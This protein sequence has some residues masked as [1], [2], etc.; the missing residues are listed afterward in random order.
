MATLSTFTV[1]GRILAKSLAELASALG[2]QPQPAWAWIE[3]GGIC[4][5]TRRL[6]PGDLFVAIP[7]YD[8][9][10][11]DFMA[12]AIERGAVAVL[13]EQSVELAVPVLKAKCARTALAQ[14]SAVFYDHPTRE[15][16]TV[17]VT[18]TNGKTTTCHWSAE[19]LGRSQTLLLSTVRNPALGISG[20]TTPPSSIIQHLARGAVEDGTHNMILE[21]SSA[22][23]AQDRVS[24][25]DFDACVFTNFSPE[26]LSHHNGLAAYR[27]AKLKLFEGLKPEAWAILNADDALHAAIAK[28]TSARV[29]T[30]GL[31]A[32]ADVR[33]DDI[34]F[35]AQGSR[36]TVV[37]H[38]QEP[39]AISLPLPGKHHISNALAAISVG[40][41][42]GITV[43]LIA[44]RLAQVEP[45]PGRDEVF[46]RADGLVAVI[47]FAHNPSSL[48]AVL[49]SLR[50]GY[51]RIIALFGCPG[52]GE[53]EKRVAMGEVG[54]RWADA[55]VLTS[56]NPKNED[57]LAIAR[58]I[59]IGIGDS[60]VPVTISLDRKQA[61]QL[62][63]SLAKAGDV[64]LLAG[65]GHETEQLI[66]DKRVP[67]SDAEALRELGFTESD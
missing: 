34:H 30:Y 54:G 25:I 56:D 52:D 17:G 36:F 50:S 47:D 51:S 7:G 37:V 10:G 64:V 1:W 19:L 66:E 23:I 16:F 35:G 13:S 61:I 33:A 38:G 55:I 21:A 22:G 62:A 44:K 31:D 2:S 15:L 24:A 41:V 57:P 65:K 60:L 46:R 49:K 67:F 27:N 18:G 4:E 3:I 39:E 26:H 42:K 11:S 40:V 9:D 29:L 12:R 43:P 53:H 59:Q 45:I 20:L 6:R 32:E 48:E 63:L 14:L 28:A 58:E 5:D 8:R